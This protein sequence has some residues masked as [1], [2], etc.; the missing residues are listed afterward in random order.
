MPGNADAIFTFGHSG[1]GAQSALM[2]ATGDAD[3]FTP[4]LEAI[5]AALKDANGNP[6]SDAISGA[7]CWCPITCLDEADAAYEWMMGQFDSS[8]TRE[9]GTWT[10]ALSGDLARSYAEYVNRAGF[11]DENGSA[12]TLGESQDGVCMAGSYHDYVLDLVNQSL[13]NFLA[14]TTFPYSPS[15]QVMGDG[16]FGQGL[17]GPG[18][19]TG[20][21]GPGDG[22]APSGAMTPDGSALSDG[23]V[24]PD[25]AASSGDAATNDGIA[26]SNASAGEGMVPDG[27]TA[28]AGA[29][30]VDG[31]AVPGDG[32]QSGGPASQGGEVEPVTYETVADYIASLNADEEWVSYDAASNTAVISDLGAFVRHCKPA[33]KAVGAFDA[34]DRSQAENDLFGTA[35]QDAAHF[36][37]TLA[38]LL[39]EHADEYAAL[40][41]WDD[42]LPQAYAVDL[43]LVDDE[44]ADTVRRVAIYNPLSYLLDSYELKG[45]STVAPHWRIRT[46]IAQGDTAVTCEMN[47]ALALQACEGVQ[48]VDFETVWGQGHTTAER[49]GSSTDNFIAWVKGVVG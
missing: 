25:G 6:I 3:S 40:S 27:S 38:A 14:D 44:G 42:T 35:E 24:S 36:D 10:A 1:G 37:S 31:G 43:D 32:A 11:V 16:G 34:T 45:E 19:P 30:P 47:L 8:S 22:Q 29:A 33:T 41:G 15:S 18:A 7:M 21:G 9:D 49:T 48:D 20:Q 5:G 4:Y 46:G 12:L 17:G 26:G 2:G 13:N 28:P 23:G 39:S